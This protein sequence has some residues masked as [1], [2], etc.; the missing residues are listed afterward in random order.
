MEMPDKAVIH[1]PGR[2]EQDNAGFHH[3]LQSAGQFKAYE[4]FI[5]GSF[6]VIFSDH[7]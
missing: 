4:L 3:A 5:S 6:H 2:T 1:I 7:S